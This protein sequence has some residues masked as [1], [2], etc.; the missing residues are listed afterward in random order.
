MAQVLNHPNQLNIKFEDLKVNKAHAVWEGNLKDGNGR[1][2]F[3][4]SDIQFPY[5]FKSRFEDG[6]GANPEMLKC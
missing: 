3:E 1:M 5:S 6:V 2:K 4:K